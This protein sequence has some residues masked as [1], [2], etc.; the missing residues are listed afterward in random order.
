MKRLFILLMILAFGLTDAYSQGVFNF[1]GIVKDSQTGVLLEGIN[2][3]IA[4][5]NIGTITDLSG[6]FFM[7]LNGGI[8]SVI[9]TAEGYKPEKFTVDL[10]TDK[11]SEISLV[12]T[13]D[14]K[15]KGDQIQKRRQLSTPSAML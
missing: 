7:F 9:L 6:S 3:I 15:K 14:S 4:D 11:Y 8:Y 5:K 13:E 10:R 2:V 12:P 1:T